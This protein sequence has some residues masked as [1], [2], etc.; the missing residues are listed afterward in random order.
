MEAADCSCAKTEVAERNNSTLIPSELEEPRFITFGDATGSFD[1]ASLRSGRRR[2]LAPSKTHRRLITHGNAIQDVTRR[3]SGVAGVSV[4]IFRTAKRFDIRAKESRRDRRR[5]TQ[6]SLIFRGQVKGGLLARGKISALRRLLINP[7]RHDRCADEHGRDGRGIRSEPRQVQPEH[8]LV[9]AIET[10][11][12]Q[13]LTQQ[14]IALTAMK[15]VQ[16]ILEIARGRLL[17]PL[18][19]KQRRDFLVKLLH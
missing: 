5:E 2:A 6:S 12:P 3:R 14:F 13:R 17:V 15:L 16:E 9:R 7:N 11:P 18:Q 10:Q 19:P 4:A 1:F 8:E